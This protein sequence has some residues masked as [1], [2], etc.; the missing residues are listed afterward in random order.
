MKVNVGPG[1][2][3]CLKVGIKATYD[4]IRAPMF[5]NLLLSLWSWKNIPKLITPS[6]R[7][8]IKTVNKGKPGLRYKGT[9]KWPN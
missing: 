9:T 2:I 3:Y 5:A 4:T 1:G 6:S 7:I 8:G